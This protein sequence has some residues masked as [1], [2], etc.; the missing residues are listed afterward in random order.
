M[1]LLHV[2]IIFAMPVST[3]RNVLNIRVFTG[4]NVINTTAPLTCEGQVGAKVSEKR[5]KC[6]SKTFLA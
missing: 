5:Y 3:G 2:F 1:S 4:R 6:N